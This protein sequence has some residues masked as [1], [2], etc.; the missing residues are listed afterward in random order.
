MTKFSKH[1]TPVDPPPRKDVMTQEDFRATL[2]K[3]NLST[4]ATSRLLGVNDRT[5]RRWWS[6]DAPVPAPAERF[7][8]YLARVNISPIAVMEV[9]E[10]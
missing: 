7:L 8:R 9:L 10:G 4:T 6:G 1:L 3:L 5:V 2:A